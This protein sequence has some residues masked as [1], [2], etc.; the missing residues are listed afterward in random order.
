MA[1]SIPPKPMSEDREK[2]VDI[3]Q[4]CLVWLV[5]VGVAALAWITLLGADVL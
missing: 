4:F 3:E 1:I 5:F 2:S